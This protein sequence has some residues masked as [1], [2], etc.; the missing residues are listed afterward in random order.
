MIA[1]PIDRINWEYKK[2]KEELKGTLPDSSED[3]KAEEYLSKYNRALWDY[4]FTIYSFETSC[5]VCIIKL[6]DEFNLESK[7]EET[8]IKDLFDNA[9]QFDGRSAKSG[10]H[11]LAK[12]DQNEEENFLKFWYVNFSIGKIPFGF[13]QMKE[14]I[15]TDRS[16]VFFLRKNNLLVFRGQANKIAKLI[17]QFNDD[18]NIKNSDIKFSSYKDNALEISKKLKEK[19]YISLTTCEI[20]SENPYP[21]IQASM[22]T[23]SLPIKELGEEVD[24]DNLEETNE[25]K[26]FSKAKELSKKLTYTFENKCGYKEKALINAVNKKGTIN[27]S[28]KVSDLAI[29]NF[30]M[31][32]KNFYDEM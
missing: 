31:A 25:A 7:L 19:K 29:I 30:A 28:R 27:I 32:V 13:D 17:N 16:N 26:M 12:I 10:K 15:K 14:I 3:L 2:L 24:M 5:A 11:Y 9:K 1:P 22:V 20:S 4:L 21:G 6:N 8:N 18:F 23:F